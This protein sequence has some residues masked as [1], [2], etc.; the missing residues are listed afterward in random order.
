MKIKRRHSVCFVLFTVLAVLAMFCLRNVASPVHAQDAPGASEPILVNGD[1]ADIAF[2][3]FT[4]EHHTQV[5]DGPV[6]ST[7]RFYGAFSASFLT[8][9][10]P[11]PGK[12]SP[13]T[14]FPSP[15]SSTTTPAA[16]LWKAR[17][18]TL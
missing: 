7:S 11:L 16:T 18:P 15:S 5:L 2:K 4:D 1:T 3:L 8:G 10:A 6:T 9:K 17:T 12:K 14:N 13:F